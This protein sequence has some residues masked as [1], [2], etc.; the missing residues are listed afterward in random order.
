MFQNLMPINSESV[1]KFIIRVKVLQLSYAL[2]LRLNFNS[3]ERRKILYIRPI[4][5]IYY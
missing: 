3:I 5:S 4:V 1:H 2:L